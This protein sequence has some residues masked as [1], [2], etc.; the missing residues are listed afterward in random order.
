MLFKEVRP[1][2]DAGAV[3]P[4]EKSDEMVSQFRHVGD[5]MNSSGNDKGRLSGFF[6]DHEGDRIRFFGNANG[7]AMAGAKRP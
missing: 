4:A 2:Q 1:N 3:F 6:G 7:R 5:R